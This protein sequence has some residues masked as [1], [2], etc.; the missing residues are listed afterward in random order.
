MSDFHITKE[1][2]EALI[3][4]IETLEGKNPIEEKGIE[5]IEKFL[6]EKKN[7]KV[8]VNS[9]QSKKVQELCFKYGVYW[10]NKSGREIIHL[11]SPYLFVDFY[12][13]TKKP[14]LS[15]EDGD[16]EGTNFFYSMSYI[17]IKL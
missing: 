17:E 11:G 8:Q 15:K 14:D 10:M 9:E 2:W 4:R 12:N 13:S 16:I 1:Q 5:T 3:S 7:F 6:Q